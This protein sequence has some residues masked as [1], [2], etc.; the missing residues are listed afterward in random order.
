MNVQVKR[1]EHKFYIP[2]K[3][4]DDLKFCLSKVMLEDKNNK[5]SGGYKITSLYF[6][7]LDDQ[8]FNQKLDG[9]IYREKYRIRIYD[10]DRLFGKFEVK[11]KLNQSFQAI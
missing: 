6:D 5:T 9:V 8:D 1:V 11:R 2:S 4:V 10:A 3:Y 7:T